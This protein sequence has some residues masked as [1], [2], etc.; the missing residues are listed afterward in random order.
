VENR[1]PDNS[2]R[3]T[4]PIQPPR[5]TREPTGKWTHRLANAGIIA[6]VTIAVATVW[7]VWGLPSLDRYLLLKAEKENAVIESKA[8]KLQDEVNTLEGKKKIL[9]EELANL[10]EN[11]KNQKSIINKLQYDKEKAEE[12]LAG[13]VNEIERQK[14]IVSKL[15]SDKQKSETEISDL[16]SKKKLLEDQNLSLLEKNSNLENNI[17]ASLLQALVDNVRNYL[18]MLEYYPEIV[19]KIG[20]PKKLGSVLLQ[21]QYNFHDNINDNY[22]N[23]YLNSIKKRIDRL[24]SIEEPRGNKKE[25]IEVKAV[26]INLKDVIQRSIEE[27]SK[28]SHISHEF[29]QNLNVRIDSYIQ[30]Y[31]EEFQ[32]PL[33]FRFTGMTMSI[34]DANAELQRLYLNF[35]TPT[36]AEGHTFESKPYAAAFGLFKFLGYNPPDDTKKVWGGSK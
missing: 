34:K 35:H 6:T 23:S 19:V 1:I 12:N 16:K 22:W 32:I 4:V 3:F 10:T 25:D 24:A 33:S 29:A 31:P 2:D 5:Q 26:T 27:I 11:A 14:Y 9:A 17:K 7:Q 8:N 36:E 30:K 18:G 28:W 20:I 13:L 15:Q 21:T